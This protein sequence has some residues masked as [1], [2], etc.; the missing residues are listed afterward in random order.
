MHHGKCEAMIKNIELWMICIFSVIGSFVLC[1]IGGA[2]IAYVFG[3]WGKPIAGFTAAFGWVSMTYLTAPVSK[4]MVTFISFLAGAVLAWYV[5]EPS[6]I[7]NNHNGSGYQRTH[8][9]FI[10]TVVGGLVPIM[11]CFLKLSKADANT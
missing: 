4:K 6:Y 5:L 3:W 9:P 2:G 11:V 10:V 8:I 1:G 7:P